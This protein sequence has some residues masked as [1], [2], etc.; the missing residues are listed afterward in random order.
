MSRECHQT[1]YSTTKVSELVLLLWL[2]EIAMLK[3]CLLFSVLSLIIRVPP[4]PPHSMVTDATF[5]MDIG[6]LLDDDD[7][8]WLSSSSHKQT[9]NKMQKVR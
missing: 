4:V 1:K 6:G 2:G 9:A 5:D 7:D 8:V 3:L